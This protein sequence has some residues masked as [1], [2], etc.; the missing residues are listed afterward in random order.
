MMT[1]DCHIMWILFGDISQKLRGVHIEKLL[2]FTH[3]VTQRTKL[4][5]DSAVSFAKH[6]LIIIGG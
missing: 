4:S 2:R 3:G 6:I 5:D 1:Y